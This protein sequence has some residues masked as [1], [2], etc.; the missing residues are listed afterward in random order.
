MI[1][2]LPL[3]AV[4]SGRLGLPDTP[5]A[6]AAAALCREASE[7]Y[8]ANH[9]L[10]SYL[11]ASVLGGARGIVVDHESLFV[12]AALHDLGLTDT[13]RADGCFEVVGA[14]A[15]AQFLAAQRWSGER[16]VGVRRAIV[17]HIEQCVP[18]EV[19]AVALV[20][21]LGISVDVSGRRLEEVDPGIRGDV[22]ATFPRLDFKRLMTEV[23]RRDADA[24]PD[25]ATALWFSEADLAGRIANAGFDD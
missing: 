11:W 1:D 7:P 3:D 16:A 8:L 19:G 15:A 24:Q 18:I 13:F 21:D 4:A 22:L 14:D 23:L 17:L 10:R 12:A 2:W 9:Q 20:L 25:C 5:T 6:R